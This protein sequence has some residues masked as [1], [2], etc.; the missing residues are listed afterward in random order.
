MKQTIEGIYTI[1]LSAIEGES[2]AIVILHDSLIN[3]ADTEGTIFDGKYIFDSITGITS[4]II[5]VKVP[6]NVKTIQGVSTGSTGISYD[7]TIAL[8]KDFLERSYIRAETL[9]GPVN[10]RF[11]LLRRLES[12]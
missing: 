10:M 9:Y 5:T 11:V 4:G 12:S 1:Y 7:V 2:F 8:P 6:S 3:G